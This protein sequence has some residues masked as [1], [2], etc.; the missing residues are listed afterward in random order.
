M[1]LP[2]CFKS[3]ETMENDEFQISGGKCTEAAK[4]IKFSWKLGVGG[5][6]EYESTSATAFKGAFTTDI[7]GDAVLTIPRSGHTATADAGFKKIRDT[8]TFQFCPSSLAFKTSFTLET[9]EA[10]A[11]PLYISE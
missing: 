5:E 4:A 7:T 6:C 2:W 11:K 8:S 9:D 3:D 1:A 10:T